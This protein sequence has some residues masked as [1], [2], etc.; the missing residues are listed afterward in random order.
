MKK[1]FLSILTNLV[2]QGWGNKVC[3][4]HT[5]YFPC[6]GVHTHGNME[7]HIRAVNN[8][9]TKQQQQISSPSYFMFKIILEQRMK[10]TI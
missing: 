9:T 1:Y 4:L 10:I 2:N 5:Q 6:L 7:V 8:F 3:P